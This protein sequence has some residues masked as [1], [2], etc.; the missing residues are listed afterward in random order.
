MLYEVIT[1]FRDGNDG[2]TF[3]ALA[4]ADGELLYPGCIINITEI[5]VDD[6]PMDMVAD[7]YTC[8]VV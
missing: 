5:V 3:A 1:D 8:S 2:V 4:I 6:E 7:P